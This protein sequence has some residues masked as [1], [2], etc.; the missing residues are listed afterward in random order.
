MTSVHSVTKVSALILIQGHSHSSFG[1]RSSR[2]DGSSIRMYGVQSLN[3]TYP[4]SLCM[5]LLICPQ[6]DHFRNFRPPP[7]SPILIKLALIFSRILNRLLQLKTN[8]NVK[9]FSYLLFKLDAGKFKCKA[10]SYCFV[11][12][13]MVV[14]FSYLDYSNNQTMLQPRSTLRILQHLQ[15]WCR[16]S[17]T[18]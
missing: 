10:F 15:W 11:L 17:W 6:G 12:V 1:W 5:Y 2:S 16:D 4:H 3:S 14:K 18:G 9:T 8:L 7:F 13:D